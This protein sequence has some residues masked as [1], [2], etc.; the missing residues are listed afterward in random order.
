LIRGF[1]GEKGRGSGVGWGVEGGEGRPWEVDWGTV[2]LL[3]LG[4][5]LVVV[6]G[7]HQMV[8]RAG[9]LRPSMAKVF[10]STDGQHKALLMAKPVE[11]GVLEVFNVDR[12]HLV[13]RRV[14]LLPQAW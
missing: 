14:P 12:C 11:A 4:L 7:A 2:L 3:P 13:N 6:R 9:H 5:V 8:R 10:Q 1:P